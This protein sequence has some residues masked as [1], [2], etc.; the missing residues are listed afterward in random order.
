[1]IIVVFLWTL[2]FILF[3]V[4]G[5][6]VVKIIN[7]L[8]KQN[9]DTVNTNLDE[10]FFIGFLTLSSI[11][12]FLSIFIPIGNY[13][14]LF[15]CLLV[16]FFFI[17]N[18]REIKSKFK[19]VLG[20][21]M[22]LSKMDLIII[23][24]LF[25]FILSAV[26]HDISISD[27]GLYHAQ[28]I[29]WIRNY[30]VIPGLGNLHGRFAFNSMFFVISGPFT[31][32]IKDVLLFPLNGICFQVLIIKLYT[33]F[34]RENK[35]GNIWKAVFY[36]SV[37]LLGLY[38]LTPS[39][40]SPSP[41]TVCAI[42]IIYSFVFVLNQSKEGKQIKTFHIILINLV[43]FS[44]I[45]FKLSSL[46]FVL[47]IP[48]FWKSGMV[49]RGIITIFIGVIVLSPFF[50]RN[51]FLS[52]YLIYPF[53]GID[54]FDVDWKIPLETVI[55]EKFWIESWARIP[56]KTYAEVL[57]LGFTEWITPWF[58][59]KDGLYK[60]IF[61]FNIFSIINLIIM[62]FKRD[63]FLAKIQVIIIINLILWF[64]NAPDPRFVYGFLFL[65]FSLTV[66]YLI[67]LF[68]NST[69][70]RKFKY[71]SIVLISFLLIIVY[72]LRQYPL[73]TLRFPVMWIISDPFE[74]TDTKNY[75]TN[76]NYHVPVSDTKCFN[77]DI[78]CTPYPLRNVV[79][80][81]KELKEGFKVTKEISF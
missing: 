9:E 76:F 48:L 19:E 71:T 14:L 61:F 16:V 17:I 41:D 11:T 20:T 74:T 25:L 13:V 23:P 24:G 75:Y 31:F 3:S 79:L 7:K 49:K 37:L 52:G 43:V 1:M 60:V 78:P 5:L 27:T 26:V 68:E 33:L 70:S 50:I 42:L 65:G 29:K 66:A 32:E 80:R 77:A 64:I 53:P 39:L 45:A 51:Y 46:F 15:V 55:R 54:I 73:H 6:S 63:F 8:N 28:S 35:T 67:K 2:E 30:P 69:Y 21:I 57:S 12:G 81:G 40:N 38:I 62:L 22:S 10:F 56:Y 47:I 18:Y 36:G 58:N 4:I 59:S 44:C 72:Q 34:R